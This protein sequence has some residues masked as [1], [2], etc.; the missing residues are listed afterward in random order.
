L[1]IEPW[2]RI[3]TGIIELIVNALLIIPST[4]FLGAFPGIG[5]M[6]GAI[7]SHLLVIGVVSKGDGGQLFILAITVFI[8]C[9]INLT[10]HKKQEITLLNKIRKSV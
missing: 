10:I 9:L 8:C 2:G 4:V 3:G 6:A 1:G 5:L 7:A